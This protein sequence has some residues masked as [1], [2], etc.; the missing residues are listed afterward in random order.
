MIVRAPTVTHDYQ[1][2]M[3][4]VT[5]VIAFVGSVRIISGSFTDMIPSFYR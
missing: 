3:D 4:I 2:I 1:L 5:I